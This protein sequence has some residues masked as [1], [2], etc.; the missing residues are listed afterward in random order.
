MSYIFSDR[1]APIELFVGRLDLT[2]RLTS[3]KVNLVCWSLFVLN[4]NI[5][6]PKEY[7]S[8]ALERFVK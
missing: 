5:P 8:S 2:H 1:L 7:I 6:I 4:G 3:N